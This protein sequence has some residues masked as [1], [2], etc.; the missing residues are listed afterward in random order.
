MPDGRLADRLGDEGRRG[1]L[2]A[3][4]R[5]PAGRALPD[6]AVSR[7][8][9]PALD[10][11]EAGAPVDLDADD[12]ELL[13][14]VIGYYHQTLKESPEA[15]G[16]LE[17]RG[18]VHPELVD[19]FRLGYANRTLGYRLPAMNRKAGQ[20]I[21]TRL[22]KLGVL[23]DSGHEHLNGSLVVPI[24]GEGGEVLGAY[25]RKIT[26]AH[27]LRAGTPLHLYLPGPHRGVFNVEALVSSKEV[28]LCEALIDALTFWCA[29]FRNVTASYGVEGFTHDHLAAFKTYGTEHVLIAYDRDEAGDKAAESLAKKLTAEGIGCSRVQFP[30]GMDANEYALKVQPARESPRSSPADRGVDGERQAA[31]EP[32]DN[33]RHDGYGASR[34]RGARASRGGCAASGRSG[35][36][37][38]RLTSRRPSP[39]YARPS[40]RPL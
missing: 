4:R 40:S 32:H 25:G 26:P 22:Q 36:C 19:R 34:C 24:L 33:D 30:K 39:S 21:R 37:L 12:R 38:A 3:R 27:Q 20:E 10:R 28:I 7:R 31:G 29:G 1:Q 17:N 13:G 5:D 2:P 23:R 6:D 8:P 11:P 16:Y 18:L 9:A 14:Q 35:P 15:L